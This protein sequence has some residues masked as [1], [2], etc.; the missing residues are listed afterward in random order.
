MKNK[1]FLIWAIVL[2][3]LSITFSFMRIVYASD[4]ETGTETSLNWGTLTEMRETGIN[5]DD[6]DFGKNDSSISTVDRWEGSTYIEFSFGETWEMSQ[7]EISEMTPDELRDMILLT[8]FYIQTN[9][10]WWDDEFSDAI[11]RKMLPERFLKTET[12]TN[13][14]EE[15]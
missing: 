5:W 14:E 3:I 12:T 10:V 11:N 9:K 7:K 8:I 1:G 4:Y 6:V 13:Q 15:E 2:S